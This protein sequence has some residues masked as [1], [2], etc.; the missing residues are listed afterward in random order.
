MFRR[1]RQ[2]FS[3]FCCSI[4]YLS[5]RFVSTKETRN[6][7]RSRGT[8]RDTV[9]VLPFPPNEG[10]QKREGSI[11]HRVFLNT[12][13]SSDFASPPSLSPIEILKRKKERGIL[14]SFFRL[15]IL[16]VHFVA[17]VVL[18]NYVYLSSPRLHRSGSF[19]GISRLYSSRD[20]TRNDVQIL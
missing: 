6:G 15:V 17:H 12:C 16:R 19:I 10:D 2:R 13:F 3:R 8:T 7:R 5:K 1:R 18:M 20:S 4:K 9:D 14:L 11:Q